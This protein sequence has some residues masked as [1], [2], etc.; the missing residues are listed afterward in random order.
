M[1]YGEGGAAP[2]DPR[3]LLDDLA[4]ID[5][6]AARVGLSRTA[7]I[8]EHR[9]STPLLRAA[10]AEVAGLVVLH[11]DKRSELIVEVAGQPAQRLAP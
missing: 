8:T 9:R 11:Q 4:R 1:Q 10:T 7:V 6:H 2:H 5:A 3:R